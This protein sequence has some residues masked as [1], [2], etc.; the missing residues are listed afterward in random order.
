MHNQIIWKP[1]IHPDISS[2][3]LISPE[4]YIKTKGMDDEYM[5]IEPSYHSTNGYDF[6]LLN[7]KEYEEVQLFPIDDIIAM[8]YIPI[9][10]SLKDKRIKV[11]HING[12]T[13]DISLDN[14]EWVEDIEEWRVST[15]PGIKPNTYEVSSWGRIRNINTGCIRILTDNFRGYLGIKIDHIQFKIHRMI[16]FQF[17]WNKNGKMP[18]VNHINGKKID[19]YY[20]NLELVTRSDNL[21]HAYLMNLKRHMSGEYHPISKITNS[22]AEYICKLLI[23]YKG[24]SKD[25]FEQMLSEGYQISKAIID[26]I[27]YKKTWTSISDKYFDKNTF[28]NIRRDEV[29]LIKKTLIKCEGSSSKAFR[30]LKDKIPHLTYRKIQGIQEGRTWKDVSSV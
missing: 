17:L 3:Y 4:G 8:T 28:I 21:K 25:V 12:D 27:L 9:P 26:L 7:N 24:W 10:N 6:V 30:I 15:Y 11:S 22:D 16:A 18:T 29:L 5:I 20:K 19:N 2:G 1:I 14:L 13:R 23:K